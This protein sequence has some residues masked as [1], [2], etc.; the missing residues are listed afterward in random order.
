MVADERLNVIYVST[1]SENTLSLI[2]QYI[3]EADRMRGATR[4]SLHVYSL[5][6]TQA[7][8]LA[9]TLSTLYAAST[10][11]GGAGFAAE[12]IAIVFGRAV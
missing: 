1:M 9:E 7:E 4:A 12:G 5:Q 11:E 6:N 2:E 10:S 3:A 8:E